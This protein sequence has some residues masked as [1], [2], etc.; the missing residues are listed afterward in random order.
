MAIDVTREIRRAVDTGKVIFGIR[1]SERSILKGSGQ[2]III[3][4]NA[5][6]TARENIEHMGNV[7]GIPFY[8][9]NESGLVLGSICGKPFVVSI[10]VIED[11]GKSKIL[12][13]VKE[14]K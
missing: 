9:F 4:G 13:I 8:N 1:E 14:K 3:S 11:K 5:Q 6:K 12:D 10:M 7:A 2:L